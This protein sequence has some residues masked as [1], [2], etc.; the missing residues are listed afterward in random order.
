MRAWSIRAIFRGI[1]FASA[2]AFAANAA[3]RI[4]QEGRILGPAPTVTTPTL[5][6]TAQADA[7]VS[8]MQIFPT[9][10]AWNEDISK[11]PTLSNSDA[12]I[13][14][15]ISDL[16]SNR[17][18]LRMFTEMNYVLVPDNQAKIDVKLV[19]YPDESDDLKAGVPTMDIASLPIP[20]N[21]PVETWPV[22]TGSLTL[23]QWQQ[24]INGD[25]GDRHSI[26]VMP[27]AGFIWE[28]WQTYLTT[29]TPA[30]QASNDA[31]FDLKSNTM[32]PAGW[33]SGDAAGL[34]MFPALVRY[35]E[36]ER[37]MVEHAMRIVV[38]KS[39]QEYIYPATHWA[40]STPASQVNVPAMGQ[41]VRLKSAFTIPGT[42]TKEEKA[43][44]L[45]LKKYG[46]I[47]ADNGG[48]FSISICPDNRYPANCFANLDTIA[49]TNFEVIQST[50]ATGGP[51]SPNAPTVD[52]GADQSVSQATG[53]TLTGSAT[54]TGL[55][56]KWY[57]YPYSTPPG[58]VTFGNSA[59]LST[60]ASFSAPGTYTLMLSA[61][62]G[63]HT[64][65]YDAVIITVVSVPTLNFSAPSSSGLESATSVNIPVT[66][67]I[68]SAQTV[69]IDYAVTGGTATGGGVDYT[70]ASGTLTFNPGVITQNIALSVVNDT[71]DEPNET[72]QITLSNPVNA[73]LGSTNVHTYTINDDDSAPTVAFNATSSN[74]SESTTS[75]SIP[76][77]LSTASGQ[78][79]T[80][81]YAVTG[82]SA[83]GGG[84]DFTLAN[85]TLTFNAGTTTQNIAL[86]VVNDSRDEPNETVQI[87]LSSPTNATL[88]TNTVHTYTINDDDPTPTVAFNASGSSG[89]E[90][91]TSVTIPVSLSAASGQTVTVAY[92]VSGGT[93]TG[94]GTDFTLASGTLTFSAGTTSQ[95]ISLTV[96]N[97]S[98]DEP[99]ETIQITLSSPTNATLG[100]NTVHT[101]TILDNDN[102]PTVA[103]NAASSSGAESVTSV[104]IPVSLS[105]ASSFAIS[106]NYAVSG[107]TATGGGVDYTLASG[108][109]NF[110]VGTT[111]QNISLSVV[112]DSAVESNETVVIALSSPTNASLGTNVSHTYTILDNDTPPAVAFSAATSSG[113]ENVASVSIPV[114][115]NGP[116]NAAV[117]VNYAVT[118]GTATGGGVDYTLAS[119]TLNF[120]VGVTTQNISLTIVND[121]IN[122][123]DETIILSLSSPTNAT[124]GAQSSHT[125]TITNTLTPVVTWNNPADIA[126]PAALG[127]T[128]LNATTTV[129]GTFVYTPPSGT[130]LKPGNAQTLSVQFTPSDT[131]ANNTPPP[132]TVTINVLK[133]NATVTLGNL[134]QTF[135]GSPKS[136]SATTTPSGLTVSLTYDGAAAAPSAIGSYAV[137]ATINDANYSGSAS[138]TLVIS[139]VPSGP[140][141]DSAPSSS[142]SPATVGQSVTF[143]IGSTSP[144]P[145]TYKWDFGDG[146]V[147]FGGSSVAH[148]FNTTGTFNVTV[149]VSDSSGKSSS[150]S[151]PLSVI[152]DSSGG[153][154]ASGVD[155]D[156][157]GVSD[158]DEI[159]VGT[160]PFNAASVLKAPMTVSKLM[161]SMKFGIQLK[162][163]IGFSGVIPGMPALFNPKD[164][165]VTIDVSGARVVLT[166]DAKG[167]A[168]TDSASL[169]LKL[170]GKRNKA[171]KQFEFAGGDVPFKVSLKHGTWSTGWSAIGVNPA[172]NA[173]KAPTNLLVDFALNGTVYTST[174]QALYSARAGKGGAFKK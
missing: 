3:E 124:L 102:P 131:T 127:A 7:I 87:T 170:K 111:T 17:R 75:V 78:T 50:A 51:R 88:G 116:A 55:T 14:Q 145:L 169:M 8:A 157:D 138:G 59:A 146:I 136:A 71:L 27:G 28:T 76:V 89:S 72:V 26:T 171:T 154:G 106:V 149:T 150:A 123:S 2:V 97:D 64:V 56:T 6:N 20:T 68:A 113:A 83:T 166:L 139:A 90:S 52:A 60:T 11:R 58:T 67:G 19:D 24:D 61:D 38:V 82:G 151:M 98:L 13:A 74:G 47:V 160:N 25:G 69:S 96:N 105:A 126:Y 44:A 49:I 112:N 167:R 121:L 63:V 85:G 108:T 92:A 174:V 144:P 37:G 104:S 65:A 103:F 10:S 118:G 163:S 42:W 57:V 155:S 168:K 134:S 48:F 16:A 141:I 110:P 101:Y 34:A 81:A 93:A 41:R 23:T 161:I 54:G 94:G 91:T 114:V 153:G 95:N 109:L 119:G 39:R 70:L 43:V 130:I 30:W 107:G 156:G 5:F 80:V 36:V 18:T 132:K 45:A 1:L 173:F 21:L 46:A 133:G 162:D 33:T 120:A 115:L 122:E 117:A 135:D 137:A 35:D 129:Q 152:A 164:K 73:P 100:A 12:M 53:A 140:S 125:H 32:R 159:A 143:T 22:G 29:N 147:A 31:K 86:T 4:N 40:S 128:Q 172:Q 142:A 15:I 158:S 79:V 66:L 99:D 148:V 84:T 77:S 165:M 9:S 62:D